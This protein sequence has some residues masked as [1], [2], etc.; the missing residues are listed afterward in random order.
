MLGKIVKSEKKKRQSSTILIKGKDLNKDQ[1]KLVKSTF[2]YR[3]T[4]GNRQRE[5][6][7]QESAD[8]LPSMPLISDKEWFNS[9]AFYFNRNGKE[10]SN[11]PTEIYAVPEY[12]AES[13]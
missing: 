13:K 6:A 10:L 9:H 12:M 3:W 8:G 1:I 4:K 5:I 11:K 7:W 2:I